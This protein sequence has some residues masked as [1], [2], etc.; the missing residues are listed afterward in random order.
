MTSVCRLPAAIAT[1]SHAMGTLPRMP[2]LAP[3]HKAAENPSTTAMTIL[4]PTMM[5]IA[6]VPQPKQYRRH[7]GR[8]RVNAGLWSSQL[9]RLIADIVKKLGKPDW[10]DA[11]H[12][13]AGIDNGSRISEPHGMTRRR[14]KLIV[15]KK[16]PA[17]GLMV[18]ARR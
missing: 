6:R 10:V 14:T 1:A 17:S 7:A 12:W 15:S 8:R 18:V 4:S 9:C 2:M 3:A 16:S 13:R 11:G 5:I